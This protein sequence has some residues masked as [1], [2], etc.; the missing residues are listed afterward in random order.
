MRPLQPGLIPREPGLESYRVRPGGVTAVRMEAGDRLTVIDPQGRQPAEVSVISDGGNGSALGITA[1]APASTLRALAET[2]DAGTEWAAGADAVLATLRASGVDALD[3]RALRLF[4]GW[5]PAGGQESFTAT[6][7]ATVLVAAPSVAMSVEDTEANPP[8]DLSLEL[9]RAVPRPAVEPRLP[10]P[11]ADPV[12][13]LHIDA[14]TAMS[15]EVKAG[16][17]IQVIDVE[18]RQCSDFLAFNAA[19]LAD[20]RRAGPRHD[21]DAHFLG[22]AYPQPGLA[23]EI[24]RPGHQPV[25]R[26][27]AGHSGPARRVRPGLQR[28]VLRGP[29][30]IPVINCCDNFNVRWSATA[31][32]ATRRAGRRSTCSTTPAS[33][34]TIAVFDEP[35]SRPGDYVLMRAMNDLVCASSACPDDIDATNAW[36]PTDIHVRIYDAEQ[37]FSMAMAYRVTPDAEPR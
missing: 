36:V 35:W 20:G 19:R 21:D 23:R 1:D 17:F 33:M 8:T 12:L 18:G 7:A 28:Q 6:S 9:Q 2:R 24:L 31:I 10:A 22:L 11:L 29:A 14:A 16:Q 37:K 4:G 27:R 26:G 5:S 3:L 25:G 32:A 15:Y 34:P 30:A 13:D